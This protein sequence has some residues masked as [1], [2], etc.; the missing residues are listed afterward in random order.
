MPEFAFLLKIQ[1]AAQSNSK[2]N[3]LL[4]VSLTIELL[5]ASPHKF[6]V[7]RHFV[8]NSSQAAH[9]VLHHLEAE[10]RMVSIS[11]HNAV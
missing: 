4:A 3:G 10:I 11:S 2:P 9:A 5:E 7:V 8:D 6:I 1:T